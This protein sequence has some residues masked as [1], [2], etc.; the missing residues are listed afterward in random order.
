MDA[1]ASCA[2]GVDAGSFNGGDTES[3][4]IKNAR[5][6]FTRDQAVRYDETGK[7]LFNDL[8]QEMAI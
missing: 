7:D 4:F 3:P 1:I 6:I 5:A 8:R 2:F